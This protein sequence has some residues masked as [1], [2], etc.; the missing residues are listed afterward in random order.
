MNWSPTVIERVVQPE[1]A[2]RLG[3]RSR[4]SRRGDAH[5]AATTGSRSAATSATWRRRI[6]GAHRSRGPWRFSTPCPSV[7]AVAQLIA[8]R[9]EVGPLLGTGGMARVV[10]GPTTPASTVRVAIKLVPADAIDP[11]GRERFGR[12]A[13]SS[14]G[15]AHPNAVTAFDAGESDG[16]LYLVME[17]VDGSSL[18]ELLARRGPLR[19][20]RRCTSRTRSSP[21]SAPPMP[22][23]SSTATSSRATC[24]SATDG[25]VKLADFGIARRLDDLTSDL[26]GVGQFIGTPKYLAPEQL[27]GEPATPASRPVRRWRRALRDA[28]RGAAVR[29]GDAD[30]AGVGPPATHRCPTCAC[31]ARMCRPRASPPSPRRWPSTRP[32]ASPPP[33]RCGGR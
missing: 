29:R 1:H 13:R 21:P 18:A 3:P 11:V 9:Y 25:R 33:T 4:P 2:R 5:S 20:M 7:L 24:C 17:L 16:Y 31:C 10:R 26:T 28:R 23:A 30:G 22:P 15:F 8:S 27:A 19:S 14:A 32:I 6:I 12:E